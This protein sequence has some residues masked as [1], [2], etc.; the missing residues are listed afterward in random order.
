MGGFD[1]WVLPLGVM[2]FGFNL[3]P[4]VQEIY[5][6][7]YRGGLVPFDY[8]KY[9][10]HEMTPQWAAQDMRI[11]T[12]RYLDRPQTEAGKS[13]Y[14]FLDWAG[15]MWDKSLYVH[16]RQRAR[17]DGDVLKYQPLYY[18]PFRFNWKKAH[19]KQWYRGDDAAGYKMPQWG[20]GGEERA[21]E[22]F[23]TAQEKYGTRY[24][25][26]QRLT[27]RWL[28]KEWAEVEQDKALELAR[29]K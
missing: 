8:Q 21:R 22:E 25:H 16:R 13:Y 5:C 19:N 9:D 11:Y 29:K 20:D 18:G 1:Q 2:Y 15:A 27:L 26:Y 10:E 14:A 17:E 28:K 24:W 7:Y 6:Y 23:K 12:R 4:L 3:I